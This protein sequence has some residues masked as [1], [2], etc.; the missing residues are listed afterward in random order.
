[1]P[2]HAPEVQFNGRPETPSGSQ[3]VSHRYD[4]EAPSVYGP[5]AGV[6]VPFAITGGSA[7][8][9]SAL[10]WKGKVIHNTPLTLNLNEFLMSGFRMYEPVNNKLT[11]FKSLIIST[12]L[13]M[14]FTTIRI[15]FIILSNVKVY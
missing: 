12:L 10:G 8:V 1:M 14:S 11:P 13:K 3:P 4:T 15:A 9:G 7:H 5:A 2:S 6:Y